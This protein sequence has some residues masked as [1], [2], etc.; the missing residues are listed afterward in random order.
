[1]YFVFVIS[2]LNSLVIF[3]DIASRRQWTLL[4]VESFPVTEDTNTTVNATEQLMIIRGKGTRVVILS[5]LVQHARVVLRQ[6]AHLGMREDWV[7]IVNSA[8]FSNVSTS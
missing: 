3:K 5:C 6:A 2:G 7:W 4:A 1:M 8:A